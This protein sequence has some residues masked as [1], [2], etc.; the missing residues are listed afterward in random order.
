MMPGVNRKGLC[1]H[2]QYQLDDR[3]TSIFIQDAF[4]QCAVFEKGVEIANKYVI[5]ENP[6][7]FDMMRSSPSC[8]NTICG[9]C[10]LRMFMECNYLKLFQDTILNDQKGKSVIG[11]NGISKIDAL[12]SVAFVQHITNR[13]K[14]SLMYLTLLQYKPILDIICCHKT[15]FQRMMRILFIDLEFWERV[16]EEW[17]RFDL[18]HGELK[19]KELYP[20]QSDIGEIE[21]LLINFQ[22]QTVDLMRSNKCLRWFIKMDDNKW[23]QKYVCKSLE[24]HQSFQI[25]LERQ[26]RR[27]GVYLYPLYISHLIEKL[28][29]NQNQTAFNKIK[30][31]IPFDMHTLSI[32]RTNILGLL[33]EMEKF[34]EVYRH[35]RKNKISCN[36]SE[37]NRD[38]IEWKYGLEYYDRDTDAL[39]YKQRGHKYKNVW[40]ER[41]INK[42]YK[43]K[44][45]KI[46]YYCSK[47]C[48]KL[49]WNRY[50]HKLVCHGMRF[51]VC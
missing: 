24:S 8:Y 51:N 15:L 37:C 18:I 9:D 10:L 41:I 19:S 7:E 27:W 33:L 16:Y 35:K 4:T 40:E 39:E 43:C 2:H 48:Q 6:L 3:S 31:Y 5:W 11:R 49:D 44:R 12:F 32:W 1:L 38:Y 25:M 26:K 42:W 14:L 23:F 13:I 46:V 30:K 45:C 36:N 20:L 29:I 47:K 50:N 22:K 34:C 17:N 28:Y 21:S